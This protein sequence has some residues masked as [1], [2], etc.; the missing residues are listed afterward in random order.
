MSESLEKIYRLTK[1]HRLRK[2]NLENISGINIS[3]SPSKIHRLDE[4]QLFIRKILL[5]LI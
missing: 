1:I 5:E 4:N 2:I 3:E